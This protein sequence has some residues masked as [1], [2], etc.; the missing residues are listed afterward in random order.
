MPVFEEGTVEG[1]P[2]PER[3]YAALARLLEEKTGV[4]LRF[5]LKKRLCCTETDN[6]EGSPGQDKGPEAPEKEGGASMEKT[7]ERGA[8]DAGA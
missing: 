2:D 6:T 8:W 1:A 7:G 4:R 5:R 3:F